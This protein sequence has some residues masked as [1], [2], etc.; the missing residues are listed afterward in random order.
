[1]VPVVPSPKLDAMLD[2]ECAR[3][4]GYKDPLARIAQAQAALRLLQAAQTRCADVKREAMVELRA[5]GWSL[6]D[7][8][9]EL[10]VSRERV[11]QVTSS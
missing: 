3:I 2:R 4:E 8:A 11:R 9:H 6:A 5:Q 10:G 1:M 7:V